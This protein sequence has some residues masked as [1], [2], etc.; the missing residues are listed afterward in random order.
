MISDALILSNSIKDPKK[1]TRELAR[2]LEESR[3]SI[4]DPNVRQ[5][6]VDRSFQKL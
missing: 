4:S 5:L 2:H 1:S 3:V 6:E